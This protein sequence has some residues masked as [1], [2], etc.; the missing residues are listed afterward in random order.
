MLAGDPHQ[1][2]GNSNALRFYD[3][4]AS[5]GCLANPMTVQHTLLILTAFSGLTG[6]ADNGAAGCPVVLYPD[7]PFTKRAPASENCMAALIFAS[8]D[9]ETITAS[10]VE[11]DRYFD[12][13]SRAVA[14]E[15]ILTG[16]IPQRLHGNP[17]SFELHTTNPLVI[18][19]FNA[20]AP[21][22]ADRDVPI[23]GDSTF[24]QIMSELVIP[25]LWNFGHDEGEGSFLYL[26]STAA[27]F[28]EELLDMRLRATSS[29]LPDAAR[30]Y[31]D[32]GAWS[33]PDG[34]GSGADD[35]TAQIDFTF[36]WGDCFSGCAG[37]HKVRAVVPADGVATVYDLGGDPLPA[38]LMLSPSTRP[39]P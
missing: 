8:R 14:A 13:W 7:G 6:C 21:N 11:V 23:T 16:R 25:Q 29:K 2:W 39:P 4:R 9:T 1:E 10:Q 22:P 32:D 3:N 27:V 37:L 18:A 35:A 24:D 20:N 28:N 26:V 12:R 31:F 17:I 5:R 15:P 19:A 30:G 33:W 34:A 38:N 36:G